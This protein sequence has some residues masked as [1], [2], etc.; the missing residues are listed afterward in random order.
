MH[1]WSECCA[2][3]KYYVHWCSLWCEGSRVCW[4]VCWGQIFGQLL[5]AGYPVIFGQGLPSEIR[6]P[7]WL[8][9]SSPVHNLISSCPPPAHISWCACVCNILGFWI[10]FDQHF[11]DDLI[12]NMVANENWCR[13]W[14]QFNIGAWKGKIER[15]K[16]LLSWKV[17]LS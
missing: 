10:N 1:S 15:V 4:E 12:F 3:T 6:D 7:C 9:L 17:R 2:V 5:A 14:L 16:W 11:S 13:G 8:T